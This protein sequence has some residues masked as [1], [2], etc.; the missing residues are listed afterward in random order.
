M[1][2]V[3]R[4]ALVSYSDEQMFALVNDVAS[5]PQYMSGCVGATLL[6]S[7]DNW[8][9]ARLDL[10]WKGIKQS[11][12]TRNL[13]QPPHSMRLTLVEGPFRKFEGEWRFEALTDAACKVV[14]QLQFEATNPLMAV[15][16]SKLLEHVSSQQ[17]DALCQ[18]AKHIYG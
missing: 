17:V 3:E 9:E 15:A 11:F 4:S 16:L 1:S 18:R 8:L 10:A 12:T 13:L 5:Y 6:D 7:G 14:F 2:K